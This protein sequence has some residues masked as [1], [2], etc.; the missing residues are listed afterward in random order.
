MKEINIGKATELTS[1][2]PL[3]LICTKKEDGSANLAP[4]SFVSYLSFNPVMVG[5]AMGKAAYSGEAVKKNGKAVIVVP[6]ESLREAAI[7]CGTCSGRDTDKAA[8]F[9]VELVELQG[10]DIKI[11]ADSKLAFAATLNKTIEIGDHFLYVCNIDKIYADESKDGLFAWNG[12]AKA[13]PAREK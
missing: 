13:A 4:V 3:V 6:G 2:N 1:P 7:S 9:G 11:P 5:F 8:K 10:S 12:Y